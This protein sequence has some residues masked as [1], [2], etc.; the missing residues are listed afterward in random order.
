MKK[1]IYF[2]IVI[3]CCLS[4]I[5]CAKRILPSG[6][7][8]DKISPKIVSVFPAD[9]SVSVAKSQEITV[10]FSEWIDA[11]SVQKGIIISPYTDFSTK[12][13]GKTLQMI[14]KTP[15]KE[16]T[17]Y[18]L[19]FLSEISD[20]S[21]NTLDETQTIIFSTGNFI[22]TAYVEGRIFFEK[23]DAILP[24]VALFFENRAIA[25]DS[26]LLS[27]SDYIVQ[28]DSSGYFKFNC[29]SEEK[30]RIIAFID[31]NRDNKI[32]PLEPIFISETQTINTQNF[33]ELLPAVCD[34][35]QNGISDLSAISPA[36]L[37]IKFK[38][39]SEEIMFDSLK[40]FSLRDTKDIR[41]EKIEKIHDMPV[42]AVFLID[43]LQNSSYLFE[44]KSK[45]NYVNDGD[46]IFCDTVKFNG[47]TFCDTIKL[48]YLDSLFSIKTKNEVESDSVAFCPKLSWNFFGEF[49]QNPL[50]EIKSAKSKLYYTNENFIENIPEGKYTI[51][52]ID[53]KNQNGKHDL[54][55]LFPFA[56][57][58]K[59]ISFFDTLVVRERW[60]AEYDIRIENQ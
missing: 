32:T 37:L 10:H 29:I 34:T 42:V 54:G 5:S 15:L 57:G 56:C 28:A 51:S 25:G 2:M 27:S 21:N 49:P 47:T 30:Y 6:G 52:L 45:K 7:E 60:E 1:K 39:F 55:T 3:I 53:D 22:D 23:H 14:P 44:M 16:N 8:G 24:K 12:I 36:I 4:Y 20:Y 40:I 43:S 9:R 35:A 38:R 58:E 59:K 19:S 26:V 11:K 46:S 50:W 41:I 17:S 33:V 31:K 18:H 13:K 48:A